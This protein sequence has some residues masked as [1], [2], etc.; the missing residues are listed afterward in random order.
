VQEGKLG[1]AV[2]KVSVDTPEMDPSLLFEQDPV[3]I[4][5]TLLPLYLNSCL[6]RSLQVGSSSSLPGAAAGVPGARMCRSCCADSVPWAGLS[7][8]P[9]CAPAALRRRPWHPSWLPA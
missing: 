5:D 8:P 6:L 1:V 4:L 9:C 7:A 3:Q 2:E